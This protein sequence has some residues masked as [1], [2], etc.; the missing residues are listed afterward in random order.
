MMRQRFGFH[1]RIETLPLHLMVCLKVSALL[2]MFNFLD[3]IGQCS[4]FVSAG[5]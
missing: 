3:S 1:T 5:M 2:S 4:N